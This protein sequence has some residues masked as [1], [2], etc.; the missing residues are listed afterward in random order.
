MDLRGWDPGDQRVTR[1][2]QRADLHHYEGSWRGS[3]QTGVSTRRD[4]VDL[5]GNLRINGNI[6]RARSLESVKA[7]GS[8][9]LR[10]SSSNIIQSRDLCGT[11][12]VLIKT[13]SQDLGVLFLKGCQKDTPQSFITRR[14]KVFYY[15]PWKIVAA[16]GII[17]RDYGNMGKRN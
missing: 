5:G 16:S 7:S 12:V 17:I 1:D 6:W 10:K 9:R 11:I 4:R 8:L 15:G 3:K 2:N 14:W 13:K